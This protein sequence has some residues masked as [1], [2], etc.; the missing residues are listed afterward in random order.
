MDPACVCA[1]RVDVG[2]VAADL[3]ALRGH[4]LGS[5]LRL[6]ILSLLRRFQH[7]VNVVSQIPNLVT[8]LINNIIVSTILFCRQ[9]HNIEIIQ[10]QT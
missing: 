5:F 6:I 3:D 9:F 1:A 4:G 8:F 10:E 7:L 2:Q